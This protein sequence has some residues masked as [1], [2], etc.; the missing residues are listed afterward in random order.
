MVDIIYSTHN[1]NTKL[2]LTIS[3]NLPIYLIGDSV[4]V[5][6]I[7]STWI[8]THNSNRNSC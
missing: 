3:S 1:S 6:Y 2:L 5:E 7:I 4:R 8:H